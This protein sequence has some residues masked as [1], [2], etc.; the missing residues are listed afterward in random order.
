MKYTKLWV[1]GDTQALAVA[2]LVG[3]CIARD[4]SVRLPHQMT[5]AQVRRK[6]GVLWRGTRCASDGGQ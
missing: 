3:G 2:R 6:I 1:D 5:G 4:G